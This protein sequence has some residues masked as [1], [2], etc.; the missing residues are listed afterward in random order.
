METRISNFFFTATTII[1]NFSLAFL[2][3]I[4]RL[5][6]SNNFGI[7]NWF[8]KCLLVVCD[9]G[10]VLLDFFGAYLAHFVEHKVKPFG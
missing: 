4:C 10:R 1:I 5:G 9:F 7:I 6:S 3:K 2:C 8:Q